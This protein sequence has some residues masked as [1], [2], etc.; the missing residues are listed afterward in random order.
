MDSYAAKIAALDLVMQVC[1]Q[2]SSG[3]GAGGPPAAHFAQIP[4]SI[5][6]SRFSLDG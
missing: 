4:E 1:Q 5:S 2:L 6:A 3:A